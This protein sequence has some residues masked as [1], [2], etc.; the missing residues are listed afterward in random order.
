MICFSKNLTLGD[1]S[2][3]SLHE[4]AEKDPK[5]TQTRRWAQPVALGG[6]LSTFAVYLPLLVPIILFLS[7]LYI[8]PKI[9]T[10]SGLGFLALR[11]MLEGGPFNS[12][13]SADPAN[14]ANDIAI[15]L[16]FYTPGQ[17][18]VPS[19]FI[20]LGTSYGLAVSLTSLIATLIGV[21]G[22]I[23]VARSFSMRPFVLFVFVL[24]LNTFSYVTL[25]FRMYHGGELLLFATAPWSLYA[26]RWSAN[27]SPILCF[28][29]SLLSA[30]LL[31]FA[32]PTGL[33]VFAT[34][35]VAIGV[36]ALVNQRR[37]DPSIFAMWVASAIGALCFMIFWVARGPVPASGS[38][39]SFSWL[40]IWFSVASAAFSGISGL[41]FLNWLFQHRW[42]RISSDYSMV[43]EL[44]Y[45]LGPLALLLMAWVWL[46]L[47][48]TGYRDTAVLL[49]SIILL[50]A[51]AVAA[52]YLWG[53]SVSFAERHF[54][55]A[56]ILFFLLLLTTIDQWR[57]RFA[58]GFACLVVVVL[59]VY[60]LNISIRGQLFAQPQIGNY[61]PTTGISQD[62]PPAVLQYLRS[63]ATRHNFQHPLAVIVS[64]TAFIS[65]PRFRI[66]HP[67]GGWLG[68]RSGTKW[69]GRAEKIFVVLPEKLSAET[70]LRSLT[71]YEFDKWKHT[72][73]D[74][75][76]IYTQ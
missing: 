55:Y 67:F 36:I 29:I 5:S 43:I 74:G 62:I 39:V 26:M 40:P 9:F 53:A 75:T 42:V 30:A 14:I 34:N 56:G 46:R 10:D 18:L 13:T 76:I 31:F 23:Q 45:M 4:V 61:D 60:G 15:F 20:W 1:P 63:E 50:Y 37:L 32:K 70:I 33:I 21:V 17:Y 71:S 7:S 58:R 49:L 2:M 3:V 69:V 19:I 38:T 6:K 48:Y 28:T 59:G 72:K 27:K 51:I 11:S 64:P 35:V 8:P 73:L 44:S 52:M 54:R 65:L 16:T 47:R 41:E 22:W 66:L 12:I 57:V 24:G 25:Q 68:Q